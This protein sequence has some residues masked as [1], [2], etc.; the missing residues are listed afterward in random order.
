MT[1]SVDACLEAA[2]RWSILVDAMLEELL[3]DK[4]SHVHVQ[5]RARVKSKSS[6][7]KKIE[8]KQKE[9]N[10]SLNDVTDVVG[11]RFVCH[12]QNEVEQVVDALLDK[13]IGSGD[14]RDFDQL[15]EAR[16]YVS[17]APNQQTLLEQLK[18]VFAKHKTKV[19]I[20]V[21]D[22]RYTSVHMVVQ[23]KA[24]EK[25]E[26][27]VRNV[28]E[29]AW[30]EIEHALKYK[31]G[32]SELS[33]SAD[34][35]LQVL[36]T[37][38]Q[39]CS[40]YSEKILLDSLGDTH[41][42]S[43]V[44]KELFE[45]QEDLKRMP[46]DARTLIQNA[47]ELRR[48]RKYSDAI[49]NL[50]DFVAAND[51][52]INSNK[53]VKYSVLMERAICYLKTGKIQAAI[54]DYS[55]LKNENPN[56]A[57]IYFRLADAYRIVKDFQEAIK[58]LELIPSKIQIEGNTKQE[59]EFL[60]KVPFTL[61]HSYWRL[62][63]PERAIDILDAAIAAGTIPW[64]GGEMSLINCYAYYQLEVA[65]VRK[66]V[67]PAKKLQGAYD[68]L[69]QCSVKNGYHWAELDTFMI[70][71]DLLDKKQ[72]A[73]ECAHLLSKMLT[74]DVDDEPPKI[75]RI[76][77]SVYDVPLEEIEIVRSHIDRIVKKHQYAQGLKL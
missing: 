19:K 42:N 73:V 46:V 74:Y 35:H 77:G 34:R 14:R 48:L 8:G 68:S 18:L 5:K 67:V 7:I 57:L 56:R 60:A 58:Y 53:L 22:S 20:D 72:E 44:V 36:N 75:K 24:N 29:D 28:F 39:A 40:E 38:V 71:C 33:P 2:R 6:L 62:H 16:I 31:G 63:E 37:F 64:K 61:A 30:A 69:L 10:Y 25:F 26:I 4:L 17:S 52:L 51:Q 76:D 9:K 1:D 45:D 70:I 27:Q 3:I 49:T 66:T 41:S 12:F 21:K 13:I 15:V 54:N 23:R 32:R 55:E 11:F 47:I 59:R 65:K 50:S 43:L